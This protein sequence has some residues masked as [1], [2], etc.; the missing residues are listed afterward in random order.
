MEPHVIGLLQ[1]GHSI[2]TEMIGN[3]NIRLAAIA[4]LM[5]AE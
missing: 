4:L 5:T 3:K 1:T 2:T